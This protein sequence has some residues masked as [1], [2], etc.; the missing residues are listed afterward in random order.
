LHG[1]YKAHDE[2]RQSDQWQRPV[3]DDITL[4]DKFTQLISGL[5]SLHEEPT[6]KASHI[7]RFI[8]EFLGFAR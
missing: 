7:T 6:G 2:T 8:K 5:A 1:Q 3:A 4:P